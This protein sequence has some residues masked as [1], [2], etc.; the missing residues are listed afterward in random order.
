MC[1]VPQLYTLKLRLVDDDINEYWNVTKDQQK[2]N[3][4]SNNRII[5]LLSRVRRKREKNVRP[6]RV[7]RNKALTVTQFSSCKSIVQENK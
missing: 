6:A 5:I 3:V 7:S 2:F 1:M 4:S